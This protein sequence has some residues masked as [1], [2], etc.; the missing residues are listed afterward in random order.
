MIEIELP[1]TILETKKLVFDS[2]GLEIK[3]VIQEK[4]SQ[5]YAAFRLQVNNHKIIFR[6]AKTTPTKIGQFVTLWKR[7]SNTPIEP[8]QD[9]DDFDFVII[10]TKTAVN[11]GLFVFSKDILIQKGIISTDKKLGKLGFR[12]YPIWDKTE[13]NQAKKT[14]NW[15]TN[16]FIELPS[17]Q[18]INLELVKKLFSKD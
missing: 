14:Q 17:D 8:F 1:A 13:N 15:Q 10:K 16:Y 18:A 6:E 11:K 2:L 5:Q 9:A 12:V 3:S 7:I 4:E